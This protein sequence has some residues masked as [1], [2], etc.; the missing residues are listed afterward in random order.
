M[1]DYNKKYVELLEQLRQMKGK[2]SKEDELLRRLEKIVY[3]DTNNKIILDLLSE[4]KDFIQLIEDINKE[5]DDLHINISN[6]SRNVDSSVLEKY[7]RQLDDFKRLKNDII[8]F[9]EEQ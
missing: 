5:M 3:L 8:H 1:R 7:Q 9:Y 2:N 4:D 6:E